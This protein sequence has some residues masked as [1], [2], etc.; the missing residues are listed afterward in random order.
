M[1]P[2]ERSYPFE[3]DIAPTGNTISR[4]LEPGALGCTTGMVHWEEESLFC[5]QKRE[6]CD[7]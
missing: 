2:D 5:K 1:D 7:E 3:I 6:G 4:F